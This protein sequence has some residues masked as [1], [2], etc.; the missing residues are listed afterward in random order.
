MWLQGERGRG[1]EGG[2]GRRNTGERERKI[3]EGGGG[4][5][6]YGKRERESGITMYNVQCKCACTS[7]MHW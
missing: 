7:R 6:K 1:G 3:G 4:K 5:E 2:E